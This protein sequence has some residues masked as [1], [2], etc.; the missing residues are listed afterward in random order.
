MDNPP[1]HNVMNNFKIK[2][3]NLKIAVIFKLKESN[4]LS[5]T[6]IF[7]NNSSW[8]NLIIKLFSYFYYIY[9]YFFKEV[10]G[11][12]L[13]RNGNLNEEMVTY[14]TIFPFYILEI[15]TSECICFYVGEKRVLSCENVNHLYHKFV[16]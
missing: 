7:T 4:V 5:A 9:K 6:Y 15:S 2:S 10:S 8:S 3:A 12:S 11:H 13:Y 14:Q 16:V 1:T